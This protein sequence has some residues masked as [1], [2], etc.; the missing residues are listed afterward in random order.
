MGLA[1]GAGAAA[2]AGGVGYYVLIKVLETMNPDIN[3]VC[4]VV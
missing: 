1:S 2:L 3:R 4:W